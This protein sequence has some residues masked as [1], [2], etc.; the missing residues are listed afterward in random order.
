MRHSPGLTAHT[1]AYKATPTELK[2][3]R[4]LPEGDMSSF[5]THL[6][7]VVVAGFI[8]HILL[9]CGETRLYL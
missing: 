6:Y 4:Y 5:G 8:V 3:H 7:C 2:T 1:L 9:A